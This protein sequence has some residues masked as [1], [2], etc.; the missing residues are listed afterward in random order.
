[1]SDE[2]PGFLTRV[3]EATDTPLVLGFGISQ[4]EHIRRVHGLV[5]GVIVSSAIADL[6]ERTATEQ[7]V[8]AVA[9][10]VRELKSAT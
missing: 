5:D 2:L 1:L 3:R 10:R 6:L 8:T 7:R 4:P 9:A